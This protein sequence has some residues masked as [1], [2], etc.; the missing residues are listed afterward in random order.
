[1]LAE[2]IREMYERAEKAQR[3]IVIADRLHDRVTFWDASLNRTFDVMKDRPAHAFAVNSIDDFSKLA[4]E[5]GTAPETLV[6]VGNHQVAAV[7]DANTWKRDTIRMDLTV[8]PEFAALLT[9]KSGR[10]FPQKDMITWLRTK[11][12]NAS[13][14]TGLVPMLRSIRVSK[15][16]DGSAERTTSEESLSK[17]VKNKVWAGGSEI[18][19]STAFTLHVYDQKPEHTATIRCILDFDFGTD[20][21]IIAPMSGD[22]ESAVSSCEQLIAAELTADLPF[23]VLLGHWPGFA[24]A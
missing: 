23:T 2:F 22:L 7:L 15:A 16:S 3:P 19:D 14:P 8:N 18:P 11:L 13:A 17:A 1:M 20:S 5:Y 9:L 4:K 24:G 12:S 21:L 10:A 6:F